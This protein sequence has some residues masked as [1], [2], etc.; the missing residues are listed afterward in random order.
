MIMDYCV[1]KRN[2]T[3]LKFEVLYSGDSIA[4]C[5]KWLAE[6]ND[7]SLDYGEEYIITARFC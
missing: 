5:A 3:T 1:E 6:N 2:R 7:G 4:E